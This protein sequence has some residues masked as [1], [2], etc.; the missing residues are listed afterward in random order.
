V[1]KPELPCLDEGQ[2]GG[3]S[4]ALASSRERAGLAQA[5]VRRSETAKQDVDEELVA[6]PKGQD[7]LRLER[8]LVNFQA[9]F[10]D[11]L[12]RLQDVEVAVRSLRAELQADRDRSVAG[13]DAA[14]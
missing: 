14:R 7:L 11:V 9:D 6:V 4:E 8:Q 10:M 2:D 3:L 12:R 5:V 13:E 1:S